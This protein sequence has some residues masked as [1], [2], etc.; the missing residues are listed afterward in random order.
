MA[1]ATYHKGTWKAEVGA[2][3]LPS[4]KY[5]G[6]VLLFHE[7]SPSDRQIEHRTVDEL[8][9]IEGAVEEASVLA[10]RILGN[11]H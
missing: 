8:D 11:L 2:E 4:G 7:G 9:T 6:I 10:Q 5:Q 1:A 3:E